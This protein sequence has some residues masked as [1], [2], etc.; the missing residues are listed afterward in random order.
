M[1]EN[2]FNSE[3]KNALDALLLHRPNITAG[4]MFGYPA[5]YV[6]GKLF[7]CVYG[8][9]VGIKVPEDVARH[10]L[11]EEHIVP[12]QPTGKPKMREWVQ[13]NRL[14]LKDY[15]LESMIRTIVAGRAG[16]LTCRQSASQGATTIGRC[17]SR[18]PR[19]EPGRGSAR[20]S[21]NPCSSR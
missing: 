1:A 8:D 2:H 14:L 16:W 7:A 4:K 12:L 9:G 20:T 11:N 6:H 21:G 19:R 13:I 10:L 15:K 18:Q 3:H 17:L 5:Y